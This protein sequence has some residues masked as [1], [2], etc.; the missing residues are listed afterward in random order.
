MTRTT[1]CQSLLHDEPSPLRDV[2]MAGCLR[3][4]KAAAMAKGNSWSQTVGFQRALGDIRECLFLSDLQCLYRVSN[5]ILP[6]GAYKALNPAKSASEIN[7]RVLGLPHS[8][9]AAITLSTSAHRLSA[10]P[11]HLRHQLH[12]PVDFSSHLKPPTKLSNS[13]VLIQIYAVAIDDVDLNALGSKG[14]GDVGKWV[15]GRSFVGRCLSVGV[16]EKEIVRG[17]IVLG[18]VDVRKVSDFAFLPSDL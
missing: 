13:Q 8:T 10:T 11:M 9:M 4:G 15:P 7:T 12:P 2:A 1:R 17:D 5:M 6:S 3:N 16:E 18:L 14:K